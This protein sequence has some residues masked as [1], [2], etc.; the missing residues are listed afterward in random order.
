M[1]ASEGPGQ[2]LTGP[3]GSVE[4]IGLQNWNAQELF[5][6]IQEL[7]PDRPF[8]ACAAVMKLEL[9]FADAAAFLYFPIN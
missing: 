3:N 6:A 9:G 8:S 2:V 7:D 5:D 1:T 4:F